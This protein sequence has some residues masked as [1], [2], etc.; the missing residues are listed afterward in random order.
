MVPE[1]EARGLIFSKIC[2]GVFNLG[3][4]NDEL[5]NYYE[6]RWPYEHSKDFLLKVMM[7][8]KGS[9]LKYFIFLQYIQNYGNK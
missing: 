6:K 2:I 5:K 8:L 9:K 7:L 1:N 3:E 4:A